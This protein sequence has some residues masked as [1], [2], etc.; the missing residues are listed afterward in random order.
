MYYVERLVLSNGPLPYA[1]LTIIRYIIVA[2]RLG[3][4]VVL[5]PRPGGWVLVIRKVPT[6]GTGRKANWYNTDTHD[7]SLCK[8][9]QLSAHSSHHLWAP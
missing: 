2:L 7:S 1:T 3:R 4:D 9:A 6:K 8:V 5:Y